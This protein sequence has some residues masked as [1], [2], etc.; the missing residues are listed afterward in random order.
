MDTYDPGQVTL[1]VGGQLITGY[2]DG[3]FI[4]VE[5]D[6]DTWTLHTGADGEVARA[7]N[8]NKAGKIVVRVQQT[9]PAN[10]LLS[11][12]HNTDEAT[13]VPPGPAYLRDLLGNTIVG[14]DDAFLL[15]PAPI[16]FGK[17]I[18]GREWTIVVPKLEGVV[19]GAA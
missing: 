9:S 16:E 6:E 10:D 8:R 1:V 7:R 4:T 12:M 14:G 19:G 11:A 2:M 13:G 18:A 17:E 3:T 15:K 5:R